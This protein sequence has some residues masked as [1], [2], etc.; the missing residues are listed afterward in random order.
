PPSF[1][2]RIAQFLRDPTEPITALD[3]A[4]K[5]TDDQLARLKE[6]SGRF[7]AGRD[8]LGKAMQREIEGMGRDP[9]RAVL[10]AALRRS[11]E[12][13]RAM[14]QAALEEAQAVLSAEQWRQLPEEARTL[15][16]FGAPPGG[17]P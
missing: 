1:A 10:F 9:D 4:L 11:M 14:A 15:P 3:V 13:G 17:R 5:L 12:G 7:V 16:R 2:E 6:I 8:S